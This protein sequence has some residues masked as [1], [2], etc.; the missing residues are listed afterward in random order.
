VAEGRGELP[1]EP[2]TIAVRGLG[3]AVAG[4]AVGIAIALAVPWILIAHVSAPAGAPN[5]AVKPAL[6][7]PVQE[8]APLAD[9]AG[10]RRE[11][12]HRLESAGVD[13]ATGEA[14]IPIERAMRLLAERAGAAPQG[15]AAR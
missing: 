4:I 15:G 12:A 6:P 5:D 1:H 10:F 9:I 8:T 7:P 14:H 13:P 11:K 3:I 2:G